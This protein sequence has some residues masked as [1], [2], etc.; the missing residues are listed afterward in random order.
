MNETVLL[1]DG[2]AVTVDAD[3]LDDAELFETLVS[4]DKGQSVDIPAVLR[5]LL[6]DDGKKALYEHLRGENGRV[7]ISRVAEVLAEIFEGIKSKK[8]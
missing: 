8:N 5:A 2:F 1:S 4:I 6:G 3:A 7:K